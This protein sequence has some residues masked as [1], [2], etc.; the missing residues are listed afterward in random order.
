MRSFTKVGKTLDYEVQ[1]S[2]S[3]VRGSVISLITATTIANAFEVYATEDSKITVTAAIKGRV[4][5]TREF[6]VGAG[7]HQRLKFDQKLAADTV[8]TF[9]TNN[10]GVYVSHIMVSGSKA[11]PQSTVLG[12][13]DPASQIV[14]GVRLHL[15]VS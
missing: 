1:S 11:L 12:L 6:E 9:T 4:S 5:W 7:I 8:L 10:A 13:V 15:L 2:Q 14:E 3:A